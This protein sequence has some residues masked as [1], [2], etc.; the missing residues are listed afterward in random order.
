MQKIAC[1]R[2]WNRAEVLK[3]SLTVE[4]S[5]LRQ[6]VSFMGTVRRNTGK[7]KDVDLLVT[8]GGSEKFWEKLWLDG[9]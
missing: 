4:N 1:P 2:F 3:F 6:Q 8:G 5:R 7:K 9:V